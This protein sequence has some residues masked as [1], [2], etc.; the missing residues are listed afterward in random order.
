[1][2][3]K[4]YLAFI[5]L[6]K[7]FDP[8]EWDT[9]FK[10]LKRI[11]INWKDRRLIAE[12]YK[13][14]TCCININGAE[15]EAIIRKGVRQGCPL[16]PYLFNLFIEEVIR[17]VKEKTKGIKINGRKIQR[18]RFADDIV[19]IEDSEKGIKKMIQILGKEL[20]HLGLKI[21]NKKT[22]TMI[23]EKT[24]E[25]VGYKLKLERAIWNK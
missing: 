13:N 25:K 4:I 11:N 24:T 22:K 15:T 7:T 17:S 1:M 16:S 12:I 9:L 3:R 6:E 14:Q 8:V 10:L 18:I 19:I 2:N 21:N 23:V 20:Q 5:D